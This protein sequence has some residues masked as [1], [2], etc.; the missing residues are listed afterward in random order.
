M[1]NLVILLIGL[2]FLRLCVFL[3]LERLNIHF[4][5]RHCL[6]LPDSVQGIM[7]EQTFARSIGYTK[8]KAKFSILSNIYD[9]FSFDYCI[10]SFAVCL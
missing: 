5:N 3:F 8:T 1:T 7:D 6:K 2:L 10:R 4:L 9:D